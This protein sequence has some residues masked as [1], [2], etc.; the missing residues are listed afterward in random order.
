[1]NRGDRRQPLDRRSRLAVIL[2]LAVYPSPQVPN[3]LSA[4]RLP[5]LRFSSSSEFNLIPALC[6]PRVISD[7]RQMPVALIRFFASLGDYSPAQG[8]LPLPVPLTTLTF[9]RPSRFCPYAGSVVF[10]LREMPHAPC[11]VHA[12]QRFP[13]V[14]SPNPSGS[15]AALPFCRTS[16]L[17]STD[18]S[19]DGVG[20]PYTV[21]FPLMGF[22]LRSFLVAPFPFGF[23][24]APFLPLRHP[25]EYRA[26]ATCRPCCHSPSPSVLPPHLRVFRNK[27]CD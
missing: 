2:R 8:V 25:A 20:R 14:G 22:A 12:L 7:M 3:H 21:R 5:L 23:P 9:C 17:C 24:K 11:E 26:S 27:N 15:R 18:Q 10:H 4:F 6:Q 1:V 13:L 16:R 19:L